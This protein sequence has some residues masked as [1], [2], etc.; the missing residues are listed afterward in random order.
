MLMISQ[1]VRGMGKASAPDADDARSHCVEWGMGKAQ[2]PDADD[3]ALY[4][5]E[6]AWAPDADDARRR[7]VEWGRLGC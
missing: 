2:A 4:G 1:S 6:K 5:I 7:F 3:L